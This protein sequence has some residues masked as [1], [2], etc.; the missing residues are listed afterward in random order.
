MSD[1]D[2]I[3]AP[4]KPKAKPAQGA[5]DKQAFAHVEKWM[6]VIREVNDEAKAS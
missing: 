4:P 3:S 5:A 2:T 6:K 1:T